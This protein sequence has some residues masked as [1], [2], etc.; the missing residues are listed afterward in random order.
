MLTISAYLSEYILQ[1]Q[2]IENIEAIF[3]VVC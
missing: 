1:R 3:L 2:G